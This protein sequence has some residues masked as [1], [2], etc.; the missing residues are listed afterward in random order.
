MN[1][2]KIDVN[3]ENGS[4]T[5]IDGAVEKTTP[6]NSVF[7]SKINNMVEVKI[8]EV[9]FSK[10]NISDIYIDDVRLSEENYTE[11]K[12]KLFFLDSSSGSGSEIIKP[13]VWQ[14]IELIDKEKFNTA[15]GFS[16][17]CKDGFGLVRIKWV[18]TI[19]TSTKDMG[20]K[21]PLFQLPEGYRFKGS[22][23]VGDVDYV[24]MVNT[25]YAMSM[26]NGVLFP[27]P[28]NVSLFLSNERLD[29]ESGENGIVYLAI[30]YMS[31][32]ITDD[33]T[34]MVDIDVVFDSNLNLKM[35]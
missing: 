28:I 5:L 31:K 3:K 21:F 10:K 13:L 34:A 30:N 17:F 32:D 27:N 29:E 11:Q 8:F 15:D 20:E 33:I 9:L 7:L 24:F 16:G 19:K 1:E 12:N 4:I 25:A 18:G 6:V 2:L 14:P 23:E 22:S 35:I 26:S